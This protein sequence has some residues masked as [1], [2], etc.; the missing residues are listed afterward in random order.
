MEPKGYFENIGCDLR[1]L[2]VAALCRSM[3]A[4]CA[5]FLLHGQS[6]ILDHALPPEG[7]QYLEEDLSGHCVLTVGIF[8][9]LQ[10]LERRERERPDRKPGLA[11]SQFSSVHRDRRYDI[12]IE[13]TN[14]TASECAAK[15]AAWLA[16]EPKPNAFPH[17]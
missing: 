12:D 2:R 3:N 1:W 16:L 14:T 15:L 6:V 9:S 8:C 7:W 10:E 4:A 13:T 5:Q 11:A 17:Q